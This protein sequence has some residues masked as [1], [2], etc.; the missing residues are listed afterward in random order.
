MSDGGTGGVSGEACFA[1]PVRAVD[2]GSLG[3]GFQSAP[4]VRVEAGSLRHDHASPAGSDLAGSAARGV[5]AG[6]AACVAWQGAV[7]DDVVARALS[8]G[9]GRHRHIFLPSGSWPVLPADAASQWFDQLCPSAVVCGDGSSRPSAGV[10]DGGGGDWQRGW[11][12]QE[13]LRAERL[14]SAGSA[15]GLAVSADETGGAG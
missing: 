11:L 12:G 5:P 13:R 6:S 10:A 14:G 4:V 7:A 2:A 8:G 1:A 3:A 15:T 9:G